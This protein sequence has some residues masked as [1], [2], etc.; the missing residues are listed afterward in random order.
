MD[1]TVILMTYVLYYII[2]SDI[3]DYDPEREYET[4]SQS[5]YYHAH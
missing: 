2:R 1:F 5:K 3:Q 4:Q